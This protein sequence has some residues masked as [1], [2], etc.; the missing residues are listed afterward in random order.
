MS[1]SLKLDL[2]VNTHMY[3]HPMQKVVKE[4]TIIK[5]GALVVM[6]DMFI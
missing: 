2:H 5:K 6:T 1:S 4:L 3:S